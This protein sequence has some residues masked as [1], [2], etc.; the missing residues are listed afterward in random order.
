MSR[1]DVYYWKCDRS[2]AFYGTRERCNAS[3]EMEERL[4]DALQDHFRT[5]SVQLSTGTGQGNHL[6]WNADVDGRL[7]FIRVENGPERDDYLEMESAVL[8]E[9]S[10]VGVRVPRVDG[11]D[12]SY[13]NLPFAW[14]AMERIASPD[15]NHWYRQGVLDVPDTAFQI[16]RA[17]ATWQ[18]ITP[19]GFGPFDLL[20]FRETD[21]LCGVHSDY[22]HYF[23]LRLTQHLDYLV[24]EQFLTT[25]QRCEIMAVIN[26][27]TD[28]LALQRG[29]LVHK[30]LALWNILGSKS[31]IAAFID[32]D[33]AV[34]GDP[35]DDLSLLACFHDA[36]FLEHA[37]AGYREERPL[38]NNYLQRFWLHLL[39]NL[40]VK[41]VIRV[42]S[43]YFDREDHF[44]IDPNGDGATLK[45]QTEQR[46]KTA[47]RGLQANAGLSEL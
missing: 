22:A 8:K 17:V 13:V 2:A 31:K 19:P 3:E 41:A 24:A 33:D 12:A 38:P 37:L 35:M 44:L 28:L 26:A 45:L 39:R 32:F 30:D 6:T 42:G 27:R 36:E 40:I 15:L 9:V 1:R 14:Q 11:C 16:G 25:E 5:K 43:G 18:S 4:L 21:K 34:C 46:I 47:L 7:L 23:H 10:A 29:C 20:S